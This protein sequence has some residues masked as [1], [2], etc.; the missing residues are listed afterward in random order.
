VI[1]SGLIGRALRD[2]A[3]HFDPPAT[4]PIQAAFWRPPR[5]TLFDRDEDLAAQRREDAASLLDDDVLGYVLV[6]AVRRGAYAE[7]MLGVGL[8]DGL[9]PAMTETLGRVVLEADR[10]RAER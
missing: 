1:G 3:N 4:T 8:E 9:W 5:H 10:V 6:R 2:L 7:M